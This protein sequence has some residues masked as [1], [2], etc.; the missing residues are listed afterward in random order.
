MLV[1]NFDFRRLRKL[2]AIQA[3]SPVATGRRVRWN[4]LR[5]Q[6]L[7][8]VKQT[9]YRQ[10]PATKLKTRVLDIL[11]TPRNKIDGMFVVYL[12]VRRL[13]KVG[14][15]QAVSPVVVV[16]GHRSALQRLAF[17]LVHRYLMATCE[18]K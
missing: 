11:Q 10:I 3:A 17:A 18:E 4:I 6:A 9:L 8:N 15:I 1:A 5:C 7:L 2:G 14:T 16:G 13:R 12:D